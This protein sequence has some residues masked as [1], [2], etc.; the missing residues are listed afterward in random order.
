M[1]DES[2]DAP[3]GVSVLSWIKPADHYTLLPA[4]T[5]PERNVLE[6][7]WQ[8][9]A[10]D[11]LRTCHAPHP[12]LPVP[13]VTVEIAPLLR[14]QGYVAWSWRPMMRGPEIRIKAHAAKDVTLEAITYSRAGDCPDV[15]VPMITPGRQHVIK[16]GKS[17]AARGPAPGTRGYIPPATPRQM[18]LL[19]AL[20]REQGITGTLP[21][22]NIRPI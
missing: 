4:L 10:W 22:L 2:I 16:L 12:C 9:G 20:R 17:A 1:T 8:W 19:R 6:A 5:S 7:A 3:A 18:T 15:R 14:A 13:P 11:V 21:A